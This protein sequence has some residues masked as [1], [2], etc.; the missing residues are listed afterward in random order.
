MMRRFESLQARQ[1]NWIGRDNGPILRRFCYNHGPSTTQANRFPASQTDFQPMLLSAIRF[2]NQT[3]RMC[4][5][6]MLGLL[7]IGLLK[8]GLLAYGLVASCNPARGDDSLQFFETH[9]RPV[10]VE[11]CY[12]CHSVESK[13]SQ[14]ELS[15]DSRDGIRVGG[16][17]GPTVV[18]GDAEK[19]LILDA[20]R[21]ESFEMPPSGKL[22]DAVIEKFEQW[23]RGGA[24]DPRDAKQP[25]GLAKVD[26]DEAR[27]YW[28]F[29]PMQHIHA[30]DLSDERTR[31][32]I[33]AFVFSKLKQTELMPNTE[34]SKTIWLRRVTFDLIGIPPTPEERENFIENAG[35]DAFER[36]ID[37]LLAS[38]KYGERYG[39]HWL[40]LA[41]YADSN[42]ADENHGYPVAWRYRDYV[43]NAFNSDIP[44]DRFVVEQLAGDLLPA[45]SEA[46][47]GRLLTATGMLVIG[48][49]ML[50]EQDKPK[51]VADLVDEQL[52]TVGKVFLGLTLGCARCHDHKFDPIKAEDYYAMAGIF[53]STKSMEHLNFVSQWNERDLPNKQRS[54]QVVDHQ[55]RLEQ[56]RSE[57]NHFELDLLKPTFEKHLS[58]LAT[59][60]KWRA[61]DYKPS[62]EEVAALGLSESQLSQLKK[63][64]ERSDWRDEKAIE[65]LGADLRSLVK[66][67]DSSLTVRQTQA[68]IV[69]AFRTALTDV[70][71]GARDDKGKLTDERLSKLDRQIYGK[72]GPFEPLGNLE[73]LVTAD[74]KGQLVK[75]RESLAQLEKSKPALDR[76]MAADEGP[77]KL[78]AIHLRGNHLQL[79]GEPL[80]RRVP[81]ILQATTPEV[82][83]PTDHSGRLEFANWLTTPSHPLTA[84]VMVNRLWQY[85]FGE[86][87]VRSAS[88][89]G[90]RGDL[91]THPELL[92]HLANEF[93]R[94]EWSQKAMHRTL[95]LSSTYRM[96]SEAN[97]DGNLVDPDNRLLW[98]HNRRRLEIEPLRDSLLSVADELDSQIGG[99]AQPIYG[100]KFED[101]NEAK[102][103]H[104]AARRTVYLPIN[105]A[106]LEEFFA[107]FDYVDS[108]V[109]LEK[110][111]VTTVPHQAL[112]LMNHRFALHAGWRLAK[113]LEQFN[114]DDNERLKF[115]YAI[116]Y[117]REPSANELSA[118]REFLQ[119]LRASVFPPDSADKSLEPWVKLC[120]S[121]LVTNE[122]M[123]VD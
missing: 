88:N 118:A 40:D 120:R 108:A 2:G 64:I 111:P 57:L 102:T 55:K 90:L 30:P 41:R 25:A 91:P 42:G 6:L 28:S 78:V 121:L 8:I 29:R 86:G 83:F 87:L 45:E 70:Q 31:G 85:H 60:M 13:K 56:T 1:K 107:T 33:D 92:D 96:T 101:S 27:D 37:R 12:E 15:L 50:A 52:D 65:V 46:E 48:P 113:R 81:E 82:A 36:V 109:S 16:S 4:S 75:Q 80:T 114:S 11:H 98:R 68:L 24:T 54:V 9:I 116:C 38:P 117:C 14:G 110:R 93:V 115:A 18:P 74:Q 17:S 49:K 84:R 94:N 44:Y 47:R 58:A 22:D 79:S 104:D 32:E 100:A 35:P 34:S 59:M 10:L 72:N 119:K 21:H 63:F 43:V 5:V 3:G 76:A 123:Y 19:S 66:R 51:L 23:I 97:E 20:L 67:S 106:A 39:R 122:F 89:F 71:G 53:H 26:W 103:I 7:K 62:A 105:R 73:D 112:F 77:V 99:Q 61:E 69:D 95:V